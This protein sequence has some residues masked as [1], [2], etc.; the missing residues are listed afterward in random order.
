[1]ADRRINLGSA[2]LG[3]IFLSIL[4]IFLMGAVKQDYPTLPVAVLEGGEKQS[5]VLTSTGRYQMVAWGATSDK[6]GIA[7][8]DTATGQVNVVYGTVREENGKMTHV[9]KLGKPFTQM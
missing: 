2:M 5:T 8:L 7:V 3:G 1:M 4:A 6:G 9:D